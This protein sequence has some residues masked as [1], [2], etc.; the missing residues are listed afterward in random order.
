[1]MGDGTYFA[2]EVEQHLHFTGEMKG[3]DMNE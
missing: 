1:M 2:V 3:G